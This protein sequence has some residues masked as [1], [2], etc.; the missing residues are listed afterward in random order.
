MICR[1]AAPH[2]GRDVTEAPSCRHAEEEAGSGVVGTVLASS[3]FRA[4]T[5]S[6]ASALGREISR[7]L[8]G[9]R[10]RC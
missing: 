3:A 10:R 9:I 1:A 6:A 5:R 4:F 7:G 2:Y 8:F